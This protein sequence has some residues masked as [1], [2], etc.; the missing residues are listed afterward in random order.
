[1]ER[2]LGGIFFFTNKNKKGM[3]AKLLKINLFLPVQAG[4]TVILIF[5]SCQSDLSFNKKEHHFLLIFR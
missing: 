1:L 2:G 3:N 4:G 5:M